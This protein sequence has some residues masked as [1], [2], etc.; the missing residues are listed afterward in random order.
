MVAP[1]PDPRPGSNAGL[2]F[3]LPPP[4]RASIRS[5]TRPREPSPGVGVTG[6]Y[7]IH[8]YDTASGAVTAVQF[9]LAL[10]AS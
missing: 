4:P 7:Y 9:G 10:N 5:P 6:T 3:L 1:A 2:A 8:V